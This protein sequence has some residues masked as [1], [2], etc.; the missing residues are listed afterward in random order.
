MG[1]FRVA[2][3]AQAPRSAMT[4]RS[5]MGVDGREAQEGGVWLALLYSRNQHNTGKQLSSNLKQEYF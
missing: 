4:Q 1:S 2:Q 3:E 5:G